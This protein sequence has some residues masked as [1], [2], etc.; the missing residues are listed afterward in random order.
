MGEVDGLD[1]IVSLNARA[2]GNFIIVGVRDSQQ[3]QFPIV[4]LPPGSVRSRFE[5]L[6]NAIETRLPT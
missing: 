4:L 5:V 3:K 6:G 1:S 2:P